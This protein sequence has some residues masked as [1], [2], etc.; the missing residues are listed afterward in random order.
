MIHSKICPICGK[1]FETTHKLYL[2]CSPECRTEARRGQDRE[3]KKGQ[4]AR[5]AAERNAARLEERNRRKADGQEALRISQ[6]DFAKRC[7]EGD[8]AALML[9]EQA[10]HGITGERYWKL[11]A[12]AAR[13][14]AETGGDHAIATVNGFSVFS[15]TFAEDVTR[16]I[17]TGAQV[18]K[19][20]IYR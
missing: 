19:G 16:S 18:I 11:Y 3:R 12:Q 5:K 20:T 8:P 10:A 9:R 6:E 2:Y 4:T 17:K 13:N 1:A 15:D 7:R 14:E